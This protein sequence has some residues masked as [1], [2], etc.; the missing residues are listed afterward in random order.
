METFEEIA[1]D[2]GFINYRYFSAG[3]A[4]SILLPKPHLF[5]EESINSTGKSECLDIAKNIQDSRRSPFSRG[6]YPE[7]E[8][9][10]LNFFRDLAFVFKRI[11]NLKAGKIGC[12][13]IELEKACSCLCSEITQT[14]DGCALVQTGYSAI[15][16]C[17]AV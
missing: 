9:M 10:P 17:S 13:H 1:Q 8:L 5:T 2:R 3:K 16:F 7:P 11:G 4:S 12:M 15:Y 14:A 6:P